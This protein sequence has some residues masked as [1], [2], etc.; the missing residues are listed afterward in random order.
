MNTDNDKRVIIVGTGI[1]GYTVA[2]ELRKLE[3]QVP[4]VLISEDA[5]DFY[6]K[7]TLSNALAMNKTP[8]NL[9][10]FDAGAM[11]TQLN[12][13]II[14]HRKVERIAVDA[15][16]VI[17]NGAPL[18]YGKLVLALG[19]DARR[20][21]LAGDA[22]ADVL[23]VNSL[24]D[25]A[26]F[27]ARLDGAKSVAL[28]GAGLIG[29]EFANDLALGGYDV[30]LIDP[31]ATPLSRLLPELAGDA[32]ARALDRQGIRLRLGQ[33]VASVDRGASGYAVT[34]GN[35]DVIAA[36]VVLSAIGLAPRVALAAQ[37]GID[38]DIGIRTDAWCRTSAADIYAL[39]DCAAIEGKVQP[40]VLPI[41]HAARALARTLSGEPTRV[42]F[43]FMPI[44]VKSPASPTVILPPGEAGEWRF[45]PASADPRDGLSALCE[46]AVDKRALGFALL[47]TATQGNAELIKA[48][49]TGAF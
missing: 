18:R 22:A 49:T 5:G 37:S 28:L 42:E 34:L 16:E 11:R 43:P 7:P 44:T 2:R 31:A 23:S 13:G 33:S 24:D 20:V 19:A 6:S 41:M 46:H 21:P 27:R 40:Y 25:Y 10:T 9:I 32:Y 39:G 17:V 29:C 30:T 26:R 36:D 14:A 1:A 47:G 45:A 8:Q 4:I 35:G 12:A 15:H 3:K 38:V 48:M